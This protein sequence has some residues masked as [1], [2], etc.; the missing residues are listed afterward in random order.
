MLPVIMN[1]VRTLKKGAWRNRDDSTG[2]GTQARGPEFDP[3]NLHGWRKWLTPESCPLTFIHHG[4]HAHAYTYG[5]THIVHCFGG[6][7]WHF[8]NETTV[9]EM[10]CNIVR[11]QIETG[12][13]IWKEQRTRSR[14]EGESGEKLKK[15]LLVAPL[16]Y[17]IKARNT[18]R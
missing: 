18:Q 12:P 11:G 6:R 7:E 13:M 8:L 1:W 16:F 9:Q 14:D 5:H 15:K 2:K 17:G 10:C 3:V 4:L